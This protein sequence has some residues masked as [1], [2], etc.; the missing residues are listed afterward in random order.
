MVVGAQR[1]CWWLFH[2][3]SLL[4]GPDAAISPRIRH[5]K[6]SLVP[7]SQRE[8]TKSGGHFPSF[9]AV[10]FCFDEVLV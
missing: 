7:R 5:E 3:R 2:S 9:R 4:A 10:S 8:P 6:P 1:S